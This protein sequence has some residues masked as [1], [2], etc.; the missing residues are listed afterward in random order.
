MKSKACT[1]VNASRNAVCHLLQGL[2]ELVPFQQLAL[3]LQSQDYW[4]ALRIVADCR[5]PVMHIH[6]AA[7]NLRA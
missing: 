7:F 5:H 3:A 1:F 4:Q 6:L 2:E